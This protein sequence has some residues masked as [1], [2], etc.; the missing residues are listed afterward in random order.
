MDLSEILSAEEQ[1]DPEAAKG[2]CVQLN[3]RAPSWSL[4][5]LFCVLWHVA[6]MLCC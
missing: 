1:R 2:G 3:P 5:A 6:I 4:V